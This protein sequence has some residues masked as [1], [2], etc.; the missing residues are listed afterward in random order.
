[1][2]NINKSSYTKFCPTHLADGLFVP[3]R[4]PKKKTDIKKWY[5]GGEIR[6]VGF[7]QLGCFDQSI[8]LAVCARTGMEGLLVKGDEKDL[9]GIKTQL[10]LPMEKTGAL[11]TGN[12]TFAKTSVYSI[13]KDVGYEKNDMGKKLYWEVVESLLR[14]ANVTVYR[15]KASK[16]GSMN[17]LN[18]GHDEHG[19]VAITL[20]WRLAD[21]ILGG[22]QNI[23]I[24]LTERR[25][26]K[27]AVAKILHAWL[28]GYVRLGKELMNGQGA[29][30]DT[31]CRHVWGENFDFKSRSTQS[32]QRKLVKEALEEIGEL[33]GWKVQ[34]YKT[35][36]LVK[37]SNSLPWTEEEIGTPGEIE[38]QI[39]EDEERLEK[40]KKD[41]EN[42]FL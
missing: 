40:E 42:E 14:L 19:R 4:D 35:K 10:S 16:G 2:V 7:A 26:L 3:R 21:A 15:R 28:C 24:S 34:T 8:L 39:I 32:K 29:N 5:D 30:Y 38:D 17:L 27:T 33:S 1:M 11:A 9:K 25:Q 13:L 36:V 6:F 41:A 31:L 18:F 20:N 12:H 23:Q 22:M 37:R